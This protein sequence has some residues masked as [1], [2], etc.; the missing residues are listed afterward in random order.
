LRSGLFNPAHVALRASGA[1]HR[2]RFSAEEARDRRAGGDVQLI[3]PGMS[4]LSAIGALNAYA[5]RRSSRIGANRSGSEHNA[6]HLTRAEPPF[7]PKQSA[8]VRNLLPQPA[9][10]A[11]VDGKLTDRPVERGDLPPQ[12]PPP[13]VGLGT[14]ARISSTATR[15]A[16]L[17]QQP[18][19]S[20]DVSV[21]APRAD[22]SNSTI[23]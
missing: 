14:S 22:T 1:T 5:R 2:E 20:A 23:V 4:R 9:S 21:R 11:S 7:R 19:T 12:V 16:P 13:V 8:P 6:K 18:L 10:R 17:V 15:D 3:T